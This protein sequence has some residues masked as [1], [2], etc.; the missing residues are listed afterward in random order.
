MRVCLKSTK[1]QTSDG[2][3]RHFCFKNLSCLFTLCYVKFL[4]PNSNEYQSYFSYQL[5]LSYK[6][7]SYKNVNFSV[8]PK[9]E[10]MI[11]DAENKFGTKVITQGNSF[12][13]GQ[14]LFW[15]FGKTGIK[16]R[17][18]GQQ[19][20]RELVKNRCYAHRAKPCS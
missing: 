12:W 2:I 7:N 18:E 10:T 16:H 14:S 20:L 1:Y 4:I 15:R 6:T 9:P 11:R 17:R 5:V 8:N 19:E 13:K 3:L